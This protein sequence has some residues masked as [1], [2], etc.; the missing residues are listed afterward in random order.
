[1]R[2]E[3]RLLKP[4]LPIDLLPGPVQ[5]GIHLASATRP[6]WCVWGKEFEYPRTMFDLVFGM[7]IGV[8]GG[9]RDPHFPKDF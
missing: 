9:V 3:R 8:V 7:K 1:M 4:R 5:E 2:P 6:S